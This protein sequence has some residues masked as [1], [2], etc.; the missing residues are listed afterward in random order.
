[1]T[2]FQ[3]DKMAI[4]EECIENLPP[5]RRPCRGEENVCE[6]S[7]QS[8]T[9]QTKK[10]QLYGSTPTYRK[11]LRRTPGLGWRSHGQEEEVAPR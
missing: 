4:M 3:H 6:T 11:I 8:T 2:F 1:M 9:T 5:R 10:Q 7:I